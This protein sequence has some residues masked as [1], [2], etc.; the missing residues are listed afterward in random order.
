MTSE[1]EIRHD[2]A[3]TSLKEDPR[4]IPSWNKQ[5]LS[6]N[7]PFKWELQLH[8]LMEGQ[9]PLTHAITDLDFLINNLDTP[10]ARL[11]VLFF[12]ISF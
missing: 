9:L 2:P 7:S 4:K 3:D 11:D 10:G 5:T 6:R 8:V 1:K 12:Q